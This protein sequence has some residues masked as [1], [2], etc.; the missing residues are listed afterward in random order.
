[1]WEPAGDPSL[2]TR[3]LI[4]AELVA[5]GI[6]KSGE[7]AHVGTNLLARPYY[8]ATGG[9]DLI[10]RRRNTVDHDVHAG[11]LI[12]RVVFFLDPG[13]AHTAGVIERQVTVAAL[14]NVPTENSGIELGRILRLLCRYLEIADLPVWH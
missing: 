9:F 3:F 13:P 11:S 10:Q 2:A 1:M 7:R 5:D 12:R 4:Q 6:R 8:P 14:T